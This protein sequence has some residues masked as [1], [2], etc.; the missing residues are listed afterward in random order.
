MEFI[1]TFFRDILD[2]PVYIIVTVICSILI[3]ACIGYLAEKRQNKK[4]QSEQYARVSNT[5]GSV[6]SP[7]VS[8]TVE[9]QNPVLSSEN[10]VVSHDSSNQQPSVVQFET[11]QVVTIPVN[12]SNPSSQNQGG[13]VQMPIQATAPSVQ[14]VAPSSAVQASTPPSVSNS[15]VPTSVN[16][17]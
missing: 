9:K 4:R 15:S 1:I 16:Q 8:P 10:V 7:G 3:C 6:S 5:L 17:Q 11:P 12:S 14:P 13:M 2:G